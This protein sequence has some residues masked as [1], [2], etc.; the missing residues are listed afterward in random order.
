MKK[1]KRAGEIVTA[2]QQV[3][4]KEMNVLLDMSIKVIS[5]VNR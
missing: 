3:S 1:L 2:Q 4:P 5:P